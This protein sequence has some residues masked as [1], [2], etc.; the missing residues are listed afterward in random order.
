MVTVT[1]DAAP[2]G[3]PVRLSVTDRGP[4]IPK[5]EQEKIFERFHRLGSELRRETQGVGIGLSIVKHVTEAH[6]G[7]VWV[8]SDPGHGS[9]FI[10]E[11]PT[12]QTT[13]EHE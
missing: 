2:G 12:C 6:G 9:R 7:R 3:A 5:A 1:L 10:I 4:G 11:L 13:N 8:E